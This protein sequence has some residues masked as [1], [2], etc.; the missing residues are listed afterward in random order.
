MQMRELA[1]RTYSSSAVV[2]MLLSSRIN[3]DYYYENLAF[4]GFMWLL[5]HAKGAFEGCIAFP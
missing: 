5:W 3:R 2:F 4:L 1:G